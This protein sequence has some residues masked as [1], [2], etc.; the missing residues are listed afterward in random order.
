MQEYDIILGM[1]WMTQHSAMI[2]YAKKM[3]Q[4]DCPW[5]GLCL[6]QGVRPGEPK[7]EIFAIKA[8]RS[9]AKG[10]VRYL[11]SVVVS[12]S[13]ILRV[14]D[15]P[16]VCEYPN[17]FPEDLPGMPPHREVEFLI[18]IVPGPDPRT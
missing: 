4:L 7:Q 5:Q 6:V 18:E 11:A 1:D 17:V 15:I 9:L 10:C 14:Q 16:I 2:D 8:Y 3:V 13:S 12:S